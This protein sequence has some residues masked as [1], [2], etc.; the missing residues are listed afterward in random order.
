MLKVKN[1]RLLILGAGGHGKVCADCAVAMSGY[2]DIA[3]LDDN[4]EGS[5]VLGYSVIG[6]FKDIKKYKEDFDEFFVAVG[7]NKIRTDWIEK[8]ID[9]VK[10]I[11]TGFR[12]K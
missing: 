1:K 10:Y 4:M 12:E 2:S 7:N 9:T 6:G 8:V 11:I 5:Q 3:F